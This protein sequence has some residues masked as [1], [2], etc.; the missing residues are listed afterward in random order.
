[1]RMEGWR[2]DGTQN[3]GTNPHW[4]SKH[5]SWKASPSSSGSREGDSSSSFQ[6]Q[7]LPI[8][9]FPGNPC[10]KSLLCHREPAKEKS[11]RE[12]EFSAA[13]SQPDALKSQNPGHIPEP[14]E[15]AEGRMRLDP[16]HQCSSAPPGG[17]PMD[18]SLWNTP[19]GMDRWELH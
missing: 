17:F 7:H 3:R 2:W 8:N 1:M 13:L 4:N 10:L 5:S 19:G 9:H 14:M 18:L 16:P 11:Q 15:D 6:S 12:K